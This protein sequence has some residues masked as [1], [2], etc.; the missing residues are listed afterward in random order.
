[1]NGQKAFYKDSKSG[2]TMTACAL[3]ARIQNGLIVSVGQ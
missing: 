2:I 3:C 1:M